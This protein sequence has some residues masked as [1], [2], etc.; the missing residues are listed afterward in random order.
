[1]AGTSQVQVLLKSNSSSQVIL[2][3][4][5]ASGS[6]AS[7]SLRARP[8]LLSLSANN[9]SYANAGTVLNW[10]STY[11]VPKT[12]PAPYND[13]DLYGICPAWG[14]ARVQQ[15]TVSSISPGDLV[16]GFWPLSSAAVDLYLH[17]TEPRNH[18]IETSPW[19]EKLM[20]LYN[21]YILL[22]TSDPLHSDPLFREWTAIFTVWQS[23]YTLNTFVFSKAYHIHPMPETGLPWSP[24]D[25]DLTHTLIITLAS[26]S[27]TARSFAHQLAT[28][29]PPN[30]DPL[31]L[32]EIGS[33]SALLSS[34]YNN[35]S[36]LRF[37]HRHIPYDSMLSQSTTFWITSPSNLH[38]ILILDFGGRSNAAYHLHTHLSST[39]SDTPLTI[40]G[41]GS[42]TK[43]FTPSDWAERATTAQQIGKIQSN[44]S[45]QRVAAIEKL[46]AKE[47]FEGAAREW[48]RVVRET[49]RQEEEGRVLGVKMVVGKGIGG[50]DGVEGGWRRICEG[51]GKGDEGLVYEI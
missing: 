21:R 12:L 15:S 23:A 46:G 31:A 34:S 8:E 11:P 13:S 50:E 43:V 6:L 18:F 35:T 39:L 51:K 16:W 26:S 17:S 47:F 9:L 29:R 25:A 38:R 44:A 37:P 5:L 2:A 45:G 41:I 49:R 27:K 14:Y 48:E 33:S 36:N 30:E 20:P 4:T 22:P 19:R 7:S 3:A 1:M 24:S 42:E 32:L 28:N 10:W 40:I